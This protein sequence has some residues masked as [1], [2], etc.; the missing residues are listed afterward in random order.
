MRATEKELVITPGIQEDVD[1][2]K[3]LLDASKEKPYHILITGPRGVG[4]SLFLQ[5]CI[6]FLKLDEEKIDVRNCAAFS[7]GIIDS[8]LFGHIKD[9]FTGANK[10]KTGLLKAAEGAGF[11]ILEEI[12]SLPSELQAKILVYMEKFIFY[13]VGSNDK[14]WA[15]NKVRIIATENFEKDTKLREDFRDRFR[16][17]INVPPL[18]KRRNDILYFIAE[19]YPELK[20]TP[21]ELFAL[22]RYH[23]P[24]NLRELDRVLFE[25]KA[26]STS[27]IIEENRIHLGFNGIAERF[28]AVGLTRKKLNKINTDL[29]GDI[30]PINTM[31][32]MPFEKREHAIIEKKR[33]L[34]QTSVTISTREQENPLLI[35]SQNSS[36]KR[37]VNVDIA[38]LEMFVRFIYGDSALTSKRPIWENDV[39]CDTCRYLFYSDPMSLPM[40]HEV[41]DKSNGSWNTLINACQKAYRKKIPASPS[42]KNTLTSEKIAEH[43]L[44]DDKHYLELLLALVK[45]TTQVRIANTI[46]VSTTTMG[47]WLESARMG[48]WPPPKKEKPSR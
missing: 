22:Y 34:D 21:N 20:F 17:Q 41:I 42:P 18:Y 2:F 26:C 11:L 19:K 14:K 39:F 44:E 13:P 16:I 25:L 5:K 47:R 33:K 45:E 28:D 30:L 8:E 10:D 27:S 48:V 15:G 23:W 12:N 9:A 40:I 37:Q 4:K 36:N 1:I 24:G 31:E 7:P 6:E 43:L 38:K 32:N 3:A 29:F 46:G 35:I